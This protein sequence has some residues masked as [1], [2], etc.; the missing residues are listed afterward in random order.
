[1]ARYFGLSVLILLLVPIVSA[2]AADFGNVAIYL[3]KSITENFS[4]MSIQLEG[5]TMVRYFDNNREMVF[6]NIYPGR[7]NVQ[8]AFPDDRG[9][10]S[11]K[12]DVFPGLTSRIDIVNSDNDYI[13]KTNGFADQGGHLLTFDRKSINSLPGELSDGIGIL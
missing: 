3:D 5:E 1:M 12:V 7:Y 10:V 13:L 9:A 8:L 11:T 2:H 6:W 4:R